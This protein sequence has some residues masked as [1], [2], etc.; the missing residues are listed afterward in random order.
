MP[1]KPLG[2][3]AGKLGKRIDTR[4]RGG[5]VVAPGSTINGRRYEYHNDMPINELPP[6][7]EARLSTFEV[8]LRIKLSAEVPWVEAKSHR[9][10]R[11]AVNVILSTPEGQRNQALNTCAYSIRQAVASLGYNHVEQELLMAAQ[12]IGLPT[13]EALRTIRSGLGGAE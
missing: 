13:W 2:N 12:D 11:Q 3:T 5:M 9:K 1:R 7:L 6:W 4:G 10:L 8:P